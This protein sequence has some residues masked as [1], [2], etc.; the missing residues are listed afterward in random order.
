MA[1]MANAATW[2]LPTPSEPIQ[3][4]GVVEEDA[5]AGG[6]FG[7]PFEQEV[8]EAGLVADPRV[9]VAGW[10]RVGGPEQRSGAARTRA[11]ASAVTSS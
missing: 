8:E 9:V 11:W 7:G 4:R 1:P 3:P 6:G 10:A 5:A 2:P